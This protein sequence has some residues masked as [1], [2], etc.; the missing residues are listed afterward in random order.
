M[1]DATA[2]WDE[3]SDEVHVFTVNRDQHEPIALDIDL[4]AFP[5]LTIAEHEAVCD[6]DP[7]AVNSANAPDRVQ[8]RRLDDTSVDGGRL[9]VRLP[10]LSW[11][12]LR[13][14]AAQPDS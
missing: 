4:R 8:P 13:L 6:D 5:K 1:L 7:D 3:V 11:N 9:Q 12:M 2:V 10:A 14:R